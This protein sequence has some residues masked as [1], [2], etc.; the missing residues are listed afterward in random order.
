[1]SV[2]QIV[3]F[4]IEESNIVRILC[5]RPFLSLCQEK[6]RS[7]WKIVENIV[8]G[9][10]G[11]VKEKKKRKMDETRERGRGVNREGWE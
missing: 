7:S 9:R 10:E 8:G 2:R 1:M 3:Q 6:N 4:Q 11:R 5:Q